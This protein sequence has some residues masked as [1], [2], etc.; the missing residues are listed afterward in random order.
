MFGRNVIYKQ[1]CV[2]MSK[3]TYKTDIKTD[4]NFLHVEAYPNKSENGKIFV[5]ISPAL[6]DICTSL[7]CILEMSRYASACIVCDEI[8][9]S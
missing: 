3:G 5:Q 7:P 4:T 9:R 8:V 2:D 1:Y 6:Q